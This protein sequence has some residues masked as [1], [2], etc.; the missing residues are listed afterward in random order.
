MENKHKND[1]EMR[2]IL[3]SMLLAASPLLP[4]CAAP[5]PARVVAAKDDGLPAPDK[6]LTREQAT[7]AAD[8]LKSRFL[9]AM[10][11]RTDPMVTNKN[12]HEAGHDMRLHWQVFGQEPADGRSLFISLHGGGGTATAVNTQQ[13]HNQWVLYQPAEGV[14]LCP[15]S[16]VDAWDMWCQPFLDTFYHDIILM[17][18]THFNVNPNK[19]Y[20]MGY[21]AGG[22]GVWRMAPRMADTWAA[23][24]MMAGHPG[25]VR[26]ENLRNLPFMIWCGERDAAYNRNKLDAY[27]ITQ[28]DSL[29]RADPD[30]YIFEGHIVKGKPH[31]MDRVDTAAVEWMARY[32]RNPYPK[33]VV[34][35]QE[36]V[37]RKA[38]YWIEAPED[39]LARYKQVRAHIDGNTIAIDRCDYTRLTLWLCDSLVNLDRKVRVTLG[40]KTIFYKRVPR[41]ASNL[42]ESLARREDTS[43]CFPA[44]ID[45]DT[46]PTPTE[47]RHGAGK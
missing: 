38:F 16:P 9:R 20:I 12:I 46:R 36:E 24:S 43:Y 6:K 31:W 34:W 41:T 3:L 40:G 7:V 13:W 14:Y 21:S 32:R 47:R 1:M 39:E 42:A 22:D 10:R 37:L 23:A 30:G 19:V 26:L 15:H 18:V 44:R 29:H 35:Q 2:I 45:L 5:A 33:K 4:S 8:T 27:R 11:R 17:A 25:D 28:M